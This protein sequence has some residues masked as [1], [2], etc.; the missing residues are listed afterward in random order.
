MCP[1]SLSPELREHNIARE[2]AQ[3]MISGRD[4]QRLAVEAY[5]RGRKS[6]LT[7]EQ[8]KERD[9]AYQRERYQ[10]LKAER[11]SGR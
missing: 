3:A 4:K 10:R 7:P 5:W 2:K 1:P 8:R 6:K 9:R 11:E